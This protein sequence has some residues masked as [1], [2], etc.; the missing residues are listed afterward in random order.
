MRNKLS[1]CLYNSITLLPLILSH[2]QKLANQTPLLML[3]PKTLLLFSSIDT[4]QQY[5]EGTESKEHR[6]GDSNSVSTSGRR[7][8]RSSGTSSG[9]GRAGTTIGRGSICGSTSRNRSI[10]GSTSVAGGIGSSFGRRRTSS[11]GNVAGRS[12]RASA[13]RK[14]AIARRG[15]LG[16][17]AVVLK[18]ARGI[19]LCVLVDD[20]S[21]TLGAV[22]SLA[23]EKPQGLGVVDHD[24]EYGKVILVGGNRHEGGEDS[25]LGRVDVVDGFTRMVKVGLGHTVIAVQELELNH[26]TGLSLDLLGPEPRAGL[27]IDWVFADRDDLN[28]SGCG[29]V[30][31]KA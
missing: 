19:G 5:E 26:G 13:R 27:A 10:G 3:K 28:L 7:S 29:V 11:H 16:K 1:F 21:H 4:L 31:D 23:A 9:R 17:L 14:L 2:A 12:G 22:R 8:R 30:S 6:A 18:R 24:G 25:R 15:A 20:H